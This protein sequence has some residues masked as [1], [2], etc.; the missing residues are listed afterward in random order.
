VYTV[1]VFKIVFAASAVLG[2]GFSQPVISSG[3]VLN[4]ASY[5]V[6]QA[7]AP[8]SLV[9]IFGTGLS[10]ATVAGDTIPLSAMINQTSVTFNGVPAPLLFVSTGQVNAQLPWESLPQGVASGTVTV[11]VTDQGSSSAPMTLQVAAL[12]PGIFSIP[13]GAGYA[14]AINGDGSLAAPAGA[15]PGIATHPANVGDAL[16]L[17]ANGL[18]PVDT[19]VNDGAASLDKLRN[20]LTVPTVLVGGVSAKVFFSGLTPQFPGVNQINFFVPQVTGGNSLPLQLSENSITSTDK[21]VIAV[22]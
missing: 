18:G 16:I 9:S 15:I 5:Q 6:G 14:V 2:C 21:V 10:T 17:Y 11:V 13:S 20:T 3:G 22:N 8:G 1:R 19:P 7:L 12:A 4:A